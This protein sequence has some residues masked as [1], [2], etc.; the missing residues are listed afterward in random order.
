MRLRSLGTLGSIRTVPFT[1][2]VFC[3]V[4]DFALVQHAISRLEAHAQCRT[5]RDRTFDCAKSRHSRT[6]TWLQCFCVPERSL[7]RVW[8]CFL[9]RSSCDQH[10]CTPQLMQVPFEDGRHVCDLHRRHR[11]ADGRHVPRL[12]PFVSDWARVAGQQHTRVHHAVHAVDAAC[13]HV[14]WSAWPALANSCGRDVEWM[15]RAKERREREQAPTGALV[16]TVD[17]GC[18]SASRA[19]E[20][21]RAGPATTGRWMEWWKPVV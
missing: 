4:V 6:V 10:G 2:T 13:R 9:T 3:N 11:T 17:C 16:L 7:G 19:S 5:T 15:W 20:I 12:R 1:A 14:C 8:V 18:S 21:W